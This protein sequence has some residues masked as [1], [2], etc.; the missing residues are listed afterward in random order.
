MGEIETDYLVVGAGASGMAF[1]DALVADTDA[2]VVLVDR[3]HAP[4]GHWLDA[5]PFVRL[6]QPSANYGV[7]SRRLGDDRI[8]ETGPNAGFY[9]R[10]TAPEICAYYRRVLDEV[11]LPS[12]QVRFLGLTDH[13]GADGD[14]YRLR[15]T[16]TGEETTVR[17]RRRLVDATYIESSIPSR[18]VPPFDADDGVR[19][20]APND[21]VDLDEPAG[22]FTVLGAGKTAMDTCAW[23][24]DAGVDPD[25][26]EWYRPRDPWLFDRAFTQ[27]LELVGSYMQLQAS[28]VAAA[29]VAGDG[30]EFARRLEDDGIFVRVDPRI[31]PQLFRGATISVAEID[32]LRSI[33]RVVRGRKV[34]RLASRS[35][36]TD[37]GEAPVEPGRVFVDCTA[38]GL[39]A[40]P[41]C[42][43][44]EP[45]RITIQ[46][47]TIGFAPWSAA[48]VAVLEARHDDDDVRNRLAPP[49]A[50]SGDVADILQFAHAGMTGLVG[51][52]ADPALSEWTDAC[53]LNPAMGAGRRT[54][55]PRV[56]EAFDTLFGNVGDAMTNLARVAGAVG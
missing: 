7:A 55:D 4:G 41:P 3:R 14:G 44:F 48:T 2:D 23:L 45:D 37:A 47:V 39:R 34:R 16:L 51:R 29:A 1:V 50:W 5:Y 32:Q 13:L 52:A 43:V 21:L 12:G 24:L 19:V 27:P 11:L 53:R 33:E 31:E 10:A 28:W 6:H 54:D 9:E 15:S 22:G 20:L 30:Q 49:V 38:R 46:Y 17:V 40:V 18:H 42:P 36:L 26:I 25:H 8:D 56:A 35:V